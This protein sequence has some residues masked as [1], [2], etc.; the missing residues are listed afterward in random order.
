MKKALAAVRAA[1]AKRQAD[2][3]SSRGTIVMHDVP[4]SSMAPLRF[5]SPCPSAGVAAAQAVQPVI[6]RH[7]GDPTLRG[8]ATL[9]GSNAHPAGPQ[10]AFLEVEPRATRPRNFPPGKDKGGYGYIAGLGVN[11]RHSRSDC[12]MGFPIVRTSRADI[13]GDVSTVA[14]SEPC[15]S[16]HGD[17][18][19]A[20][21][22]GSVHAGRYASTLISNWAHEAVAV[23]RTAPPTGTSTCLKFYGNP[24]QM[25]KSFVE[26]HT[27]GRARAAS[28]G[29]P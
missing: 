15:A 22:S 5:A 8:S 26:E 10:V 21:G 24:Q 29:I 11:G 7:R 2:G 16:P 17:L 4:S 20:R 12:G 23:S 19:L 1:R 27:G 28:R 14:I 13:S 6:L 18:R 3:L 9:D 25:W